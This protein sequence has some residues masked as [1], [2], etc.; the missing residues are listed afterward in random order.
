MH[1][2]DYYDDDKDPYPVSSYHGTHV[3]GTI[4]AEANNNKG[5]IGINPHAKIMAIRVG[6]S[7]LSTD[8]I[9]K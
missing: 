9:I 5:V 1:G 8:A 6:N 3:A 7:M 4:A 2:Y